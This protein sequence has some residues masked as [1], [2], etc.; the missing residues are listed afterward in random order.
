M[1]LIG[2]QSLSRLGASLHPQST[3][4]RQRLVGILF[5]ALQTT[6]Q[7]PHATQLVKSITIA[8]FKAVSFPRT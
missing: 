7:A 2:T 8:H 4:R 3:I 6:E 1:Q 5:V